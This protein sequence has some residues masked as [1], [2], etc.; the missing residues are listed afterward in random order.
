MVE[1]ACSPSLN[2]TTAQFPSPYLPPLDEEVFCPVRKTVN[3]LF[4]LCS[5]GSGW[6]QTGR[7]SS[8]EGGDRDAELL[9]KQYQEADKYDHRGRHSSASVPAGGP[10]IDVSSS[11]GNVSVLVGKQVILVCSVRGLQNESVGC[12]GRL[13]RAGAAMNCA[14]V[15]QINERR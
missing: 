3:P 9:R 8:A 5:A 4:S 12:G 2:Q 10:T 11:S 14:R 1:V 6:R 15:R 7:A 13:S